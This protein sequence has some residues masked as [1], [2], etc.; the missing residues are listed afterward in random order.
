MMDKIRAAKDLATSLLAALAAGGVFVI[1]DNVQA[2]FWGALFGVA[3][4]VMTLYGGGNDKP[5]AS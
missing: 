3:A 2:T 5:P 4:F 1:D